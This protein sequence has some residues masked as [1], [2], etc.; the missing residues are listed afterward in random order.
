MKDVS[1]DYINA[2]EASQRQPVELYH[3]QHIDNHWYYTSGDTPVDFDSHTWEPATI[4]RS[5]TH[6]DAKLEGT[7][8]SVTFAR[9]DP[10]IARY[11]AQSPVELSSITIYKLFRDQDPMESCLIFTGVIL[12]VT[13]KGLAAEARCAGIDYVISHQFLNW[14]YQP[15][16]NHTVFSDGCGLNEADYELTTTVSV[17][18]TGTILTSSDFSSHEDGWWTL[19]VVTHNDEERLIVDHVGNTITIMVPF[20]ELNSGDT[21]TV[22]PGCDGKVDTCRDKFNNLSHF[23]GFPFI[24]VDNPALWINR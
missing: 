18:E 11:L 13:V 8:I 10:A 20:R 14:R 12:S 7:K 17:N 23:L 4:K 3:I 19:G 24:P 1:Q 5:S 22:L 6:Y 21:V 16:C 2:E 15:E 9:T